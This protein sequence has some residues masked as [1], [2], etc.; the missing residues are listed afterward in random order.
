MVKG[1]EKQAGIDFSE[2]SRNFFFVGDSHTVGMLGQTRENV[3]AQGGISTKAM[4]DG[5]DG[6]KVNGRPL[7]LL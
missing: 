4:L 6:T 1:V 2:L 7:V 3:F 5:V